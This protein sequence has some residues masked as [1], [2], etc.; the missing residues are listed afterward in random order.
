MKKFKVVVLSLGGL[1][2]KIFESGDIV[3]EDAFPVGSVEKL[4]E[5]GF[6]EPTECGENDV[7][8]EDGDP[9]QDELH[10]PENIGASGPIAPLKDEL[11]ETEVSPEANVSTD[12]KVDSSHEANL[13]TEEGVQDKDNSKNKN[14]G[15]N[16]N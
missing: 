11:P 13:K 4:V 6:L 14:K 16:K 2:N 15:K 3:S 7:F 8:N 1:G 12:V 10:E 9:A 5:Q